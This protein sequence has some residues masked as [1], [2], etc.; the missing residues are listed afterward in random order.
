MRDGQHT[1]REDKDA[2]K[3]VRCT[4]S[5]PGGECLGKCYCGKH[6]L[7]LHTCCDKLNWGFWSD[8]EWSG[9]GVG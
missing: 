6:E 7:L 9:V 2:I 1:V 3:E 8:V 4:A 5:H